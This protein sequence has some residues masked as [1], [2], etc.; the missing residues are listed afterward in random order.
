MRLS[1]TTLVHSIY[2]LVFIRNYGFD[3][4]TNILYC[5]RWV[6]RTTPPTQFGRPNSAF[7]SNP[8][9]LFFLYSQ[10]RFNWYGV[11]FPTSWRLMLSFFCSFLLYFNAL[12]RL[13]SPL[14]C[15]LGRFKRRSH[16]WARIRCGPKVF[17]DNTMVGEKGYCGS[18]FFFLQMKS[19]VVMWWI[20]E[21]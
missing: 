1:V 14:S 12:W 3:E 16:D 15:S 17:M 6:R 18:V 2:L 13:L 7:Q 5:G 10:T 8:S 19:D 9:M 21:K 4:M 11:S 20:V